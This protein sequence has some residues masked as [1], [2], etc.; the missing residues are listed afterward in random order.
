MNNVPLYVQAEREPLTEGEAADAAAVLTMLLD[1]SAAAGD[2]AAVQ[3]VRATADLL[4]V[5]PSPKPPTT[6]TPSPPLPPPHLHVHLHIHV[7]SVTSRK[8]LR[9]LASEG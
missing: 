4:G 7:P 3:Y 5:C 8:S 2:P 9:R 1:T 6:P